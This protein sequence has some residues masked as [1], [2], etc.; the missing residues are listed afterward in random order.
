[1]YPITIWLQLHFWCFCTS[2][3][4]VLGSGDS[5]YYLSFL[6]LPHCSLTSFTRN[7]NQRVGVCFPSSFVL[8]TCFSDLTGDHRLPLLGPV[9]FFY[10]RHNKCTWSSC[11]LSC[12]L[13]LRQLPPPCCWGHCWESLHDPPLLLPQ[14][15]PSKEVNV[16]L[17]MSLFLLFLAI[18]IWESDAGVKTR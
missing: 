1:M 5:H 8:I 10:L 9:D 12:W 17:T 16:V 13:P 4:W 7:Q 14:P 3:W 18:K 11:G 15:P 2:S 6:L